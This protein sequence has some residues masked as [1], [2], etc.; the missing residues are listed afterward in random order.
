MKDRFGFD[1]SNIKGAPFWS[2]PQLGRR[3]FFRHAATAVG[4]YFLL[5]KIG[6]AHV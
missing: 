6:R 2:K 3:M 4:G 5:P 1:W